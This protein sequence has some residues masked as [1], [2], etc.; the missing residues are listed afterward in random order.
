VTAERTLV[1]AGRAAQIL[2]L[3]DRRGAHRLVDEQLLAPFTGWTLEGVAKRRQLMFRLVDVRALLVE[4]EERV[5]RRPT[6]RWKAGSQL[7]L[8]FPRDRVA[9]LLPW[10]RKPVMAKAGDSLKRWLELEGRAKAR[11]DG[12]PVKGRTMPGKKHRVA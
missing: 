10:L 3:A 6:A 4:R 11:Q 1:T 12:R 2:G 8:V 5:G 7:E 9:K